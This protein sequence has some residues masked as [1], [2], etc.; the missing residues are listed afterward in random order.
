M[1]PSAKSDIRGL[2]RRLEALAARLE[3]IADVGAEAAKPVELDQ[4]KVGRVSRM[5]AIRSQAMS[6]E[7]ERRRTAELARIRAALRRID[8]GEYG[9]CLRCGGPIAV[10]RLTIDPA[11]TLCIDCASRAEDPDRRR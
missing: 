4:T 8:N 1:S 2:R 6:V 7:A 11:A 5:D 3:S 9:D 10:E